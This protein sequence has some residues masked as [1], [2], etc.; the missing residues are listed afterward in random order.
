MRNPNTNIDSELVINAPLF[1]SIRLLGLL[2]EDLKRLFTAY[3]TVSQE[4]KE[5]AFQFY[6]MIN[7]QKLVVKYQI[8]LII[9]IMYANNQLTG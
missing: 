3:N 8:L 2:E 1:V 9:R 6:L 4:R 7:L 5:K